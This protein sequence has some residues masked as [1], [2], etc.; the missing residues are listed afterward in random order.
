MT[1]YLVNLSYDLESKYTENGMWNC[2]QEILTAKGFKI[3][4]NFPQTTV[5][6]WEQTTTAQIALKQTKNK[7][8][9]SI[10]EVRKNY[11]EIEYSKL[12]LTCHNEIDND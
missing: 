6:N 5:L 7:F 3:S 10:A 2:L 1:K 11:G 8:L 12:L 9:A 4:E